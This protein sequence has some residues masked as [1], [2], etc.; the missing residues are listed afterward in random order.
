MNEVY[1][2]VS[3]V[4]RLVKVVKPLAPRLTNLQGKTICELKNGD[5]AAI[6]TFGAVEELLSKRYPGVKFVPYNKFGNV[7]D[8]LHE[9]E[10]IKDL[11]AKLKEYHCDAVISGN[12]V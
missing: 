3:P 8:S 2:V 12:G 4:S 7:D 5:R 10:V 6:V 1:E 9:T 11:P